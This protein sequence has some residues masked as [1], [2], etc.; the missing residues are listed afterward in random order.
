MSKESMEWLNT[1]TLIGFTDQRGTA[2]HY[3][4]TLQGD[5]PNHYPGPI[6]VSDVRRRLFGFEVS[7]QPIYVRMPGSVPEPFREVPGR[8]AWTTRDT[9]EVLG[10]FTDGYLG[11]QYDEW[12]T[13]NVESIL[14]GDLGIG[15]AGLLKNRAQAWVAVEVPESIATPEGVTFRPR[16]IAA[17][18]FDGSLAT[19]YKRSAQVVV[20]DNTLAAGLSGAGERYRLK[21]TRYSNL[22]IGEA[23]QA[24]A[25]VFTMADDLSAEIK[26]LCEIEVPTPAFGRVLD[27]MIPLTDAQGQPFKGR[28]LTTA[29]RKRGEVT[30]LYR[31]DDRAAPWAGT[32]YGVL[33]AF[34]TYGHHYGTIRNASRV[35]RNASNMV[36]GAVE[37][38]DA[39][40]LA[41]VDAVLSAA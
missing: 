31:H 30:R 37:G 21:H 18:S 14:D 23:R 32:A 35:Q 12:L 29:E 3:A 8:K 4:E 19:T 11:H 34:N 39:A 10:I 41:A 7:P 1:R 6:P 25:V 5:E 17:T 38:T 26:R 15:S 27:I 28:S 40:V 20:C 36:T 24:L 22:K 9:G 33:A 13:R 2:W 16:L